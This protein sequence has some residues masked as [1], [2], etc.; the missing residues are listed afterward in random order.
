[1][2]TQTFLKNKYIAAV[3]ND[4]LAFYLPVIKSTTPQVY[5]KSCNCSWRIISQNR[6]IRNIQKI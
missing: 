3:P 4:T 1:M 2:Q 6:L 5:M